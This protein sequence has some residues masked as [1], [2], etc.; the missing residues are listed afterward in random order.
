MPFDSATH[1]ASHFRHLLKRDGIKARCRVAPGSSKAIQVFPI[2]YG[3][4]F[5]EQTQRHIRFIAECNKLT[6]VRGLPIDVDRMTDP[7]GM[8]FYLP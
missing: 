6:L 3:V 7:H 5:D 4:E 2:A 1:L 8:E